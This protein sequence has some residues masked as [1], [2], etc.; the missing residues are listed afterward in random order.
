MP[1][2]DGDV[3]T[4][5]DA[6]QHVPEFAPCGGGFHLFHGETIAYK[7]YNLYKLYSPDRDSGARPGIAGEPVTATG[8]RPGIAAPVLTRSLRIGTSAQYTG[9]SGD[10]GRALAGGISWS[11]DGLDGRAGRYALALSAGETHITIFSAD[12]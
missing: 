5:Q 10:A 8:R 1:S 3:L 6:V 9:R 12:R 2:G 11:I 4:A 7:L